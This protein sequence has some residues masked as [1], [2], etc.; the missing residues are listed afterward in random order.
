MK[1]TSFDAIWP[2]T[3]LQEGMLFHALYDGGQE[4]VD[5]YN[6]QLPIELTGPLDRAALRRACELVVARHPALRVG[7]LQRRSG[8]PFQAVASQV[9]LPW[10]ETDLTGL[11]P[12][13]Q[14]ARLREVLTEERHRRFEMTQP[15][16]LRFTLVALA[17]DRHVLV[18]TN[19]HILMDGWSMPVVVEDL[20]R[21][22]HHGGDATA[23]DPAVSVGDYLGWLGARNRGATEAAWGKALA[24]LEGPTLL[25]RGA[26]PAAGGVSQRRIRLELD[27]ERSRALAEAA[28]SRNLT[29]NTVIQGAWSLLLALMTGSDDV[30]FGCTVADRPAAVPGVDRVVG[31]L[32]NTVPARVRIDPTEPFGALLDRIQDEQSELGE[33]SWLGLADIHRISGHDSLFDTTLAFENFPLPASARGV[34]VAGLRLALAGEAVDEVPEGTHYPLSLAVFP[35][36]TTVFELNHRPDLYPKER[37]EALLERLA[38]LVGHAVDRPDTPVGRLP[39]LTAEERRRIDRAAAPAPVATPPGTL[40]DLFEAQAARTPDAPAVS[41]GA[42]KLTFAELDTAANRLARQLVA[43]GAAPERPVVMALPRTAGAVVALLAILKS[44]AVYVPVDLEQP[45]ERIA[46][47]FGELRP[48]LVVTTAAAAARLPGGTERVLPDELPREENG[49]VLTDADRLA[50]LRPDHLAYAVYTSGST[51]RPKGVAIEHRSLANMFHSHRNHL[52]EPEQAAAGRPLRAALTNSLVFDASWSQLLWMVG[53]HE[54]H[55]IEEEL[56]ADPHALL[57]HVTRHGIEVLDT[58]PSFARQLIAEGLLDEGRTVRVLALGGEAVDEPLW[59][60]L[61]DTRGLSAYNLYGPAECTVDPMYA[62]F[63][64]HEHPVIGGPADNLRAHLLDDALRPVPPGV[65]GELYLAGA[66]LARGYLGQRVL[67]AERFVADPFGAPGTRMYRTGDRAQRDDDGTLVFLGRTDDQIKI[68]GFRVEPG[69]I[70]AV[71][72]AAPEVRHAVAVAREDRPGSPV[73]VAYVVAAPGAT[74]DGRALRARAAEVLPG[75]M[76]PSAVV[77][78][79]ELPTTVNGKVDKAALPAVGFEGDGAGGEPRDEQEE[80][81]H[82]L[83]AEVLRVERIGIHDNFFNLGGDS[84]L[85]MRLSALARRAGLA[86]SPRDVFLHRTV[87]ALA[88]AARAADA[89]DTGAE[90]PA[91]GPLPELTAEERAEVD[92]AHPDA[93]EVWPLTS[94][95]QGMS[96]HA[97]LAPDR[98]DPYVTQQVFDLDGEVAPAVLR[99]A[100]DTVLGRHANLR[101]R[102]ARLRSG[103][104]VQVIPERV[105]VPWREVDLAALAL[106]EQDRRVGELVAEE[107]DRPFPI[108]SAPLLRALL[109]RLAGDRHVLVVTDHHIL[110]DGWSV[111]LFYRELFT[112][113][114]AGGSAEGLPEPVPF[115]RVLA[116]LAGRDGA[117][118]ER[119]WAGALAGLD[120]PTLVAPHADLSVLAAQGTAHAV[121]DAG[122]SARITAAARAAGITVNTL[123]N[124]A[125]AIALERLTGRGDVVFGASVS[126]RSPELPGI[127]DAIGLVMNTV[128][129]RAVLDPAEPLS[130]ALVRMQTEQ[131][132]LIA[133]HHLGLPEIQRAVGLGELFDTIVGFENAGIDHAEVREPVPGLGIGLREPSVPGSAHYPLRLLVRPGEQLDVKLHYRTDLYGEAEAGDL[134]ASVLRVLETFAEAPGTRLAALE[135]LAAPTREAVLERWAATAPAAPAATIPALFAERVAEHPGAPAVLTGTEELSYAELDARSDRLARVLLS[136]GAGPERIVAVLL[137]R[138]AELVTTILAIWK[139][140]SV[141]MPVDTDYPADRIGFMLTDARPDLILAAPDAVDGIPAELRDRVVTTDRLTAPADTP[142]GEVTDAERGRPL[143]PTCGA[144]IIFTSGSTGRPKGVLVTHA[145]LASFLATQRR[146]LD[147]GPGRKVL[148]FASPS[149]DGAMGE[150]NTAL[151]SGSCVVVGSYDEMLP[152]QPLAD[153]VAR[154]GVQTLTIPPSSLA[155]M[156]DGSLPEGITLVTGGEVLPPELVARWAPG[157]R[158]LN[159]YGPTET[160]IIATVGGPLEPGVAVSIGVPVVG[161]RIRVLDHCLRPLPAGVPGEV[162]ISGA[163][164]ARGYLHRPDLTAS[165]YVADPF[166]AP[167]DRMYRT[168]DIAR[169]LPDGRLDYVRRADDQVKLRGFRIEP[170]EIEAV[171]AA[172]P[173]VRHATVQLR[174]DTPGSRQLVAYVVP[175]GPD[176]TDPAALRERVAAHLPE[177]MVPA[178]VVEIPELPTTPHGKLDRAALPAPRFAAAE[179]SR[180]PRTPRE[181]LLRQLF[182]DVLQVERIGIDD[183]FFALGGDSIM[184]IKLV[185][186]AREAGLEISPRDVFTHKSVAEL[187]AV[188]TESAPQS[189]DEEAEEPLVD[190]DQDELDEFIAK[191]AQED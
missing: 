170:G 97:L 54:L 32:I 21:I 44:G 11:D 45:V 112:A 77:V 93:V 182:V 165:R 110:L 49:A 89:G 188:V 185:T 114:A 115:R 129:F 162:Y 27:E 101:A 29:V 64:A 6:M 51:G 10:T 23:L 55:M 154:T 12:A 72:A 113:Y 40:V 69:E 26:E 135:L 119:A 8:E 156:A 134:L 34:E 66:G 109:V 36:P 91:D 88:A 13:G 61:R 60:R 145:G 68:R 120:E 107:H 163:G 56:R 22:L 164:L 103:R 79:D 169:W 187:A 42:E 118:A 166:G 148:W 155:A 180:A 18:L 65:T 90:P 123:L 191:F 33:H 158:M 9:E 87:A 184:S 102:F 161:A 151:L 85:S 59:R 2:L 167:G 78:L 53:G 141:H 130:A 17:A 116:W 50:P 74:A 125:W 94:L 140:G 144:Y 150:L 31:L 39:L 147:L 106:A 168:G 4:G 58:T 152:G 175:A 82:G 146:H 124:G 92:A 28:R 95:Q 131:S 157:R 35:G 133:H 98:V 117:A 132:E 30:V 174:E 160:T 41:C 46:A 76:V 1:P 100:F 171:L 57:D 62:R 189:A 67:T 149:F 153:W 127:E 70:E 83:F 80:L 104:A 128:P 37:A 48:H 47:V 19:H 173:G 25:G 43:R 63:A 16:L 138:T 15:P 71:L 137:P 52:F 108:G 139:S 3:P 143:L 181:E 159:I 136:H 190:L 105:E 81:L 111:P 142:S 20:F 121:L 86:L 73:L 5:H 178:A 99:A 126:G 183:S 7:F 186:A 96:F 179:G 177:Y 14:Q 176:G 38:L 24:G 122:S 75:Y 172:D 84:L